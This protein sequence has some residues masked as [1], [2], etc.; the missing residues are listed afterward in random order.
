M[1]KLIAGL[2]CVALISGCASSSARFQNIDTSN[3]SN[4]EQLNAD[5]TPL[6]EGHEVAQ[7]RL[8]ALKDTALSLGAQGGL[9]Y[10]S[11]TINNTLMTEN[12]HLESVFNFRALLLA[13]N[14]QPPVLE[15]G[16][17]LMHVSDGNDSIRIADQTYRIVEQAR[18]A[19]APLDWQQYL[20]THFKKP[21]V[22]DKTLLPRDQTEQKVW[23]FYVR[24]GWQEGIAQ[25][26]Q[27]YVENV[28]RLERDYNGMVLYRKL[29]AEH[30]VSAPFVASSD[31]GVTSN[32][33]NT[34][35][36]INDQVLRIT[37]LPKLNPNVNE[38]K[39]AVVAQ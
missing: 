37:A 13:H 7:I 31:L 8:T 14:I 11:E 2:F 18:F 26:N 32:S 30:M 1:K 25:A 4:L 5:N 12:E 36:Y 39:P 34:Q 23:I 35:L 33:E 28:A 15:E 19:T 24:K 27:I 21:G 17:Q 6:P 20:I 29:L 3:L 16:S 38:W 22:P 10:Q 9:A